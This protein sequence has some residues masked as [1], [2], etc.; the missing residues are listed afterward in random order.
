MISPTTMHEHTPWTI[1]Y[2]PQNCKEI[3]GQERAVQQIKDFVQNHSRQKKKALLIHGPPGSGKTSSVIAIAKE[4]NRELFEVNASDKRNKAHVEEIIGNALKQRSLFGNQKLLLI[5]EVD[6]LSGDADRGGISALVQLIA[7]AT[8]PLIMTANDPYSDALSSLRKESIVI[9]LE[10][11]HHDALLQILSKIGAAENISYEQSTLLQL[12]RKAQGDV[13]AAI[14]DFELIAKTTRKVEDND[15]LSIDQRERKESIVNALVKV[16]R[17]RDLEIARTAYNNVNEDLDEISMWVDENL[18][19]EYAGKELARAYDAVSRADVF[20][21][22]IRRQQHWRFLVYIDALLSA[23]VAISKQ[24]SKKQFIR[25]E[26]SSRGLTFWIMNRKYGMRKN[27]AHKLAQRTH[28][29]TKEAVQ[30]LFYLKPAF[31]KSADNK[32]IEELRLDDDE[33]EWLRTPLN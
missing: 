22:R 11:V 15:I 3:V 1:K 17:N 33:Q 18:P 16:L 8:F 4:C 20:K 23:G 31:E 28:C 12:A 24:E 21:G 30:Q 7:G 9:G 29:S 32:L 6:G 27:I 13:R 2:Q 25:Y 26:R 19:K 14:N 5:D 10:P